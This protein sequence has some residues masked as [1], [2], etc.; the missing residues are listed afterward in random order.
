MLVQAF[1]KQL[2]FITYL[3]WQKAVKAIFLKRA[4]PIHE[5]GAWVSLDEWL[6]TI[7]D[8]TRYVN[9]VN[10]QFPMPQK[11]VFHKVS[12]P[13]NF[14]VRLSRWNLYVRDMGRCQYCG[15]HL[16]RREATRDHVIP[17]SHGGKSTWKNLVI[18]CRP[19]NEKKG[20]SVWVPVKTPTV[21]SVREIMVKMSAMTV[22]NRQTTKAFQADFNHQV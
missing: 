9:S 5:S 13:V 18:C 21:P 19:C 20:S 15:K 10:F 2:L 12:I 6:S 7:H 11:I 4:L 1:D 8:N 14:K 17:V 22:E 3:P 16:S